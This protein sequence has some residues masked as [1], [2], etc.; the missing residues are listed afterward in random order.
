MSENIHRPVQ[1]LCWD[2][3]KATGFCNWSADLRPVKGWTVKEV[4]KEQT[5]KGYLVIDCPEFERDAIGHG[6]KRY[7]KEDE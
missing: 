2:C 3:A 7:Y 4:W 5:G 6:V 1:T